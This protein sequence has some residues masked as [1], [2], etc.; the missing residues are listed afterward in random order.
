MVDPIKGC[1]DVN[2]HDPSLLKTLQ[3]TLQCMGHSQNSIRGTQT[4][5]ISKLDRWNHTTAS[6][7]SSKTNRN[8]ALKHLGQHSC[9]GN[10]SVIGHR[11]ERSTLRNWGDIGLTPASRETTQTNTPP[12]HHTKTG[13]KT[14]VLEKDEKYIPNGSVLP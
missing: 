12:K 11:G 14:S 5:P 13:S 10:R 6:H 8:Q 4:F 3:Y 1:T 9:Y 7:K 2:P